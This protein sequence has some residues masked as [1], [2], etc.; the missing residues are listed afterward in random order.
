MVCACNTDEPREPTQE[1]ATLG[2]CQHAH[3]PNQAFK[4][5]SKTRVRR[6][7][8]SRKGSTGAP[9]TSQP[10]PFPV[11]TLLFF[12]S[13]AERPFP[14][15]LQLDFLTLVHANVSKLF[16]L[17][18]TGSKGLLRQSRSKHPKAPR[19]RHRSRKK[20]LSFAHHTLMSQKPTVLCYLFFARLNGVVSDKS[21]CK[22]M[23]KRDSGC[24]GHVLVRHVAESA[25]T[26]VTTRVR[27]NPK[28]CLQSCF[29]GWT[30]PLLQAFAAM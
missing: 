10:P 22:S 15:L 18:R 27:S 8:S 7:R 16:R 17:R 6:V 2:R 5:P 29:A 26:P 25:L 20:D 11:P 1:K 21:T 14:H 13:V 4:R 3:L 24:Q 9:R 28:R 12:C 19:F 30:N 23:R